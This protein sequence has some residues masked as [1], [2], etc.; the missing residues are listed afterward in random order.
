MHSDLSK[1]TLTLFKSP[2]IF[3]VIR[4]LSFPKSLT[5]KGH[6]SFPHPTSI[7][8]FSLLK[9][10]HFIPEIINCEALLEANQGG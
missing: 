10:F 2:A 1:F 3:Y 9:P 8:L 7:K 6:F 4:A 5:I